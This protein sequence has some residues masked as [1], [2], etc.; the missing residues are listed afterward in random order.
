MCNLV[1]FEA[2]KIGGAIIPV[3][4]VLSLRRNEQQHLG[5]LCCDSTD[6]HLSESNTTNYRGRTQG[7]AMRNLV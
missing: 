5:T 4:E 7:A 1:H 6:V 2:A 3:G